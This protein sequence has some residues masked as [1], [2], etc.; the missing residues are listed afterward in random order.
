MKR[1]IREMK[2]Q[3]FTAEEKVIVTNYIKNAFNKIDLYRI[4]DDFWS[5]IISI[6]PKEVLWNIQKTLEKYIDEDR[7]HRRISKKSFK[8]LPIN[9]K[10]SKECSHLEDYEQEEIFDIIEKY[11]YTVKSKNLVLK[12]VKKLEKIFDLNLEELE[13]I[14]FFYLRNANEW[15]FFGYE[16]DRD[17]SIENFLNIPNSNI[18]K[19]LSYKNTLM[20]NEIISKNNDFA[21][22]ETMMEYLSTDS[23]SLL[24]YLCTKEYGDYDIES[25]F[26]D[27]QIRN[28][29]ITMMKKVPD[30][31]I[32][33]YGASGT[34][35]TSF[36]KSL[37]ES[38]NKIPYTLD[39]NENLWIASRCISYNEVL[40]I[41]E[42]DDLLN[43]GMF[44]FMKDSKKAKLNKDLDD[45][46]KP[47]I[48][49]TNT[50]KSA[51]KSVLRRFNYI[52]KFPDLSEK[53]NAMLWQKNI[54]DIEKILTEQEIQEHAKKYSL[55]IGIVSKA[56][57]S[58]VSCYRSKEKRKKMLESILESHNNLR[59][60]KS[61]TKFEPKSNFS[62]EFLNT[63]ISAENIKSYIE[64]YKNMD[65][66]ERCAILFHGEP[67]TG[68]T[69]FARYLAE[70]T[71][72]DHKTVSISD[73]LSPYVGETESKIAKAFK[74]AT[75]YNMVLIFDEA[76]SLLAD[77]RGA[78]RSWEVSQVNEFL[79]QLD[80]YKGVFIATTNFVKHFDMAA[81]RRFNW[82]VEFK[83]IA[84]NKIK[85]AF[86]YF[87][88]KVDFS[89]LDDKFRNIQK[90]TAGD[91]AVIISKVRF[92]EN[93]KGADI[94]DL[95]LVEQKYKENYSPKNVGF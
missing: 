82:K 25:F 5:L 20:Y 31:K 16:F 62:M 53:E 88:P 66:K 69:E 65:E 6:L 7:E 57:D 1:R 26:L 50:L 83:S 74:E 77:R 91:I 47:C 73:F 75:K 54:I 71:G 36:A 94:V 2:T 23:S 29:A 40:I 39:E 38:S 93:I 92:M 59:N 86:E 70:L 80:R 51:D 41:D 68:K 72:F 11:I 14:T 17:Q 21:L 78:T 37:I 76:D 48:F 49:I 46:D 87:F 43:E 55:P 28:N 52:I 24:D 89:G 32:L 18:K 45:I 63:D 10:I 22:S 84:Q 79:A 4:S 67:G 64:H 56:V 95:A 8:H 3:G 12:K 9:Q 60:K 61:N 42:A 81:M 15:D 44:S 34:G 19:L 30:V 85:T 13:I 27:E 33:L 35:K 90:I 58:A